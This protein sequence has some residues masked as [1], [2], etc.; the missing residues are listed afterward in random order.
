MKTLD[1]R[2]LNCPEPVLK[3]KTALSDNP[4]DDLTVFVDNETARENVMRFMRSKNRLVKWEKTADYFIVNSSVKSLTEQE[5]E[6]EDPMPASEKLA[7]IDPVLFISSDQLG[8]GSSELGHLLM[9]NFIYTLTKSERFPQAIILMN[10]AVKLSI[11]GSPALE[12]LLE[13]QK[14]G[15]PILVCGTCLDYYQLKDQ[16]QAGQ[17]SNMYDIA[18]IL[19]AADS[20]INL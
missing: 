16:H 7:K 19:M 12:S 3:T 20:V 13:L 10:S 18:D 2:G 11:A 9:R 6:A 4:G 1:C 5:N 15:V 14:C 8:K 17:V